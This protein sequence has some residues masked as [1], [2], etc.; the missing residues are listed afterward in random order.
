MGW[1]AEEKHLNYST[2]H[3]HSQALSS[4]LCF[5]CKNN[6]SCVVCT[7]SHAKVLQPVRHLY[8]D[9][10]EVVGNIEPAMMQ[11]VSSFPIIFFTNEKKQ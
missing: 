7:A 2:M 8:S 6:S 9:V 10:V 1:L 11:G 4:R 5:T 3:G